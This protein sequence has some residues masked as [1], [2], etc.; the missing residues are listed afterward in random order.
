MW[1][2]VA[3]THLL[4]FGKK[5]LRLI[6]VSEFKCN[7]FNSVFLSFKYYYLETTVVVLSRPVTL[8]DFTVT[9]TRTQQSRAF[10]EFNLWFTNRHF[11]QPTTV[12]TP[13]QSC[14]FTRT[15]VRTQSST[16]THL[17]IY[18]AHL[19]YT[20]AKLR[21]LNLIQYWTVR[22]AQPENVCGYREDF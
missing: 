7:W 6:I 15:C 10:G 14:P 8:T 11:T 1:Y 9:C 3:S 17:Y 21:I 13:W 2:L 22:H 5:C 20:G 4:C 16:L 19:T 12:N 18:C